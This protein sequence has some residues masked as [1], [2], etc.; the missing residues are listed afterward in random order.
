MGEVVQ[1]VHLLHGLAEL[2]AHG[3]DTGGSGLLLEVAHAAAGHLPHAGLQSLQ[4]RLHLLS[5]G[6]SGEGGGPQTVVIH[7]AMGTPKQFYWSF[8]L[9][10][11][12]DGFY[13]SLI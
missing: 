1:F 10:N 5:G 3:R 11:T 7:E 6:E 13:Y 9:K 4:L 2:G 8:L 12:L